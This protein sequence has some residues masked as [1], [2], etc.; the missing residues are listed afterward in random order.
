MDMKYRTYP[1]TLSPSGKMA[2][3]VGVVVPDEAANKKWVD[4]YGAKEKENP[5]LGFIMHERIN[6]L[7]KYEKEKVT[8]GG[9]LA[10]VEKKED[11]RGR[12]SV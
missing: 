8:D 5:K 11:G 4:G 1:A 3:P 10:L 7:L 2:P 6:A 12:P 9:I